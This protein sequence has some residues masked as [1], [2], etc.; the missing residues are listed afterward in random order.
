MRRTLDARRYG[1][2]TPE[3]AS[4]STVVSMLAVVTFGAVAIPARP[5]ARTGA[6]AM[7]R[8]RI[9]LSM[10]RLA[11]PA[12]YA[13]GILVSQQSGA[14]LLRREFADPDSDEPQRLQAT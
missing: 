13:F 2:G 7:G 1:I 12:V 9:A 10:D 14:L 8:H 5:V 11:T 6:T 3:P 4:P